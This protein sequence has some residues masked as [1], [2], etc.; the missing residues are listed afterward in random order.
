MNMNSFEK[1][2]EKLQSGFNFFGHF[3]RSNLIFSRTV[4]RNEFWFFVLQSVHQDASFELSNRT[5]QWFSIFT[6]VRG[7]SFDL[8]GVWALPQGDRLIKNLFKVF[9][10][11][12]MAFPIHIN[13][14]PKIPQF[15]IFSNRH[16]AVSALVLMFLGYKNC[17][18]SHGYTNTWTLLGI[19]MQ[20]TICWES[21]R[22][23]RCTRTQVNVNIQSI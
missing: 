6:L 14:R 3:W 8:G 21:C 20:H 9:F 10:L 23:E 4:H 12:L 22:V 1:N 7:D 16:S 17:A 19:A 5:I 2:Q 18:S 13:I 15:F 11:G